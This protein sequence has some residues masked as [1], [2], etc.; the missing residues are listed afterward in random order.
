MY[1]SGDH[2]Y[3]IFRR[4]P[5]GTPIWVEAVKGEESA[6]QRM[7]S[8]A[9]MNSCEYFLYDVPLNKIMASSKPS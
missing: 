6:R 2:T 5:D 7:A 8:L 1:P 9:R 3:D 4:L